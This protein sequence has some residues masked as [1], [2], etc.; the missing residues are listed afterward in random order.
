MTTLRVELFEE[1]LQELAGRLGDPKLIYRGL[2][3]WNISNTMCVISRG[4]ASQSVPLRFVWKS[5]YVGFE[6][7]LAFHKVMML[8]GV[9]IATDLTP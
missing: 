6:D 2:P 8:S 5:E 1:D 9:S 3:P 4:F 7:A